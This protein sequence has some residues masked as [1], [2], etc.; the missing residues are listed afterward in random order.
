V[1]LLIKTRKRLTT[2]EQPNWSG[3]MLSLSKTNCY[4]LN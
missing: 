3:D 4:S 1:L 2:H